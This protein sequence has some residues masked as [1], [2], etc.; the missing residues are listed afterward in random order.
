LEGHRCGYLSSSWELLKAILGVCLWVLQF[1][2]SFLWQFPTGCAGFLQ[3][4]F[5]L[6][7]VSPSSF[8]RSFSFL[9]TLFPATSPFS[10]VLPAISFRLTNFAPFASVLS[11][12]P[13]VAF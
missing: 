7:Q 1:A 2:A 9:S 5:T 8:W 13:L 3:K 6:T 12:I 10:Q 4:L 11:P